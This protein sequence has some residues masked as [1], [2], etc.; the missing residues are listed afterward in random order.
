[1]PA[2]DVHEKIDV[3]AHK[4]YLPMV[5]H[6]ETGKLL[7]ENT[8]SLIF[9]GASLYAKP[10]YG[11]NNTDAMTIAL[12]LSLCKCWRHFLRGLQ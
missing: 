10:I 6:S 7:V 4:F 2:L 9:T 3:D 1:V 12:C 11:S 8:K 5:Q